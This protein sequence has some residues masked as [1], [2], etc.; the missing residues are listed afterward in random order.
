MCNING[1]GVL[2]FFCSC[3]LTI[4]CN[5]DSRLKIRVNRKAQSKRIIWQNRNF[6]PQK[7][8]KEH[9]QSKSR[10]S[11][12]ECLYRFDQFQRFHNYDVTLC[13]EASELCQVNGHCVFALFCNHYFSIKGTQRRWWWKLS[14]HVGQQITNIKLIYILRAKLYRQVDHLS[15]GFPSCF[16]YEQDD[17]SWSPNSDKSNTSKCSE[18]PEP[19]Y[20]SLRIDHRYQRYLLVATYRS[21]EGAIA[22]DWKWLVKWVG[23]ELTRPIRS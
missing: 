17:W 20:C 12:S 9:S 21:W 2:R 4:R 5:S 19:Q 15:Y 16:I 23:V 11:I 10:E 6:H 14:D 8:R 1:R 13:W 7:V 3:Y 22:C 18:S